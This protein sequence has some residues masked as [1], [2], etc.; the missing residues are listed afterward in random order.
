MKGAVYSLIE[1]I[2]RQDLNFIEEA[3]AIESLINKYGISQE[4]AARKLGKAP[5]T[6]SNKLRIL[7]L[8]KEAQKM[9]LSKSDL[10]LNTL[11]R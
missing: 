2:Q 4:E 9:L 3:M 8:P 7:T 1:N 5:S 6:V 10:S 11:V